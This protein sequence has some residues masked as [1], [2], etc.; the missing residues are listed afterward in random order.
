MEAAFVILSN[1]TDPELCSALQQ[2]SGLRRR[3]QRILE[4]GPPLG[5]NARLQ[6]APQHR[7]AQQTPQGWPDSPG[8]AMT[9]CRPH[10]L[11]NLGAPVTHRIP[12][13][14]LGRICQSNLTSTALQSPRSTAPNSGSSR[15]LQHSSP[16]R[17]RKAKARKA[18][19][20]KAGAVASK[21]KASGLMPTGQRAARR[22][23]NGRNPPHRSGHSLRQHRHCNPVHR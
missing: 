11:R 9:A 1:A 5:S 21:A 14:A 17:P 7:A 18:K 19:R 20:R 23:S 3:I 2:N 22:T 4:H 10:P 12:A 8:P 13:P 15:R 16:L 6:S